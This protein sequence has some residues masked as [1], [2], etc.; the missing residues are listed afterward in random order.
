MNRAR[1]SALVEVGDRVRVRADGG[2]GAAHR[3]AGQKGRLES[4][5]PGLEANHLYYV[6]IEGNSSLLE[7]AFEEGDLL[8][9]T[10]RT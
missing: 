7:T 5:E 4:I 6:L 10:P 3:Y 9:H 1:S 8:K 2:S